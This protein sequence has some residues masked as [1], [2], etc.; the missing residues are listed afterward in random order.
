MCLPVPPDIRHTRLYISLHHLGLSLPLPRGPPGGLLLLGNR[1]F[2]LLPPVLLGWSEVGETLPPHQGCSVVSQGGQ[3]QVQP[4]LIHSLPSDYS[5]SSQLVS[6]GICQCSMFNSFPQVYQY[7]LACY[8][9]A[10]A[11][12]LG[13]DFLWS[14]PTLLHIHPGWHH[15]PAA[16]LHHGP[17][18]R[19]DGS[20][21]RSFCSSQPSADCPEE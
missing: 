21:P 14:G 10:T 20:A 8:W 3:S 5:I 15:S 12:L 2:L 17:N 6:L 11:A 16:H 18:H 1:S 9:S 4:S 19:G 7:C 13:W